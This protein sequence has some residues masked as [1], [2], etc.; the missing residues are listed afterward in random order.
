MQYDII[1]SKKIKAIIF[2]ALKEEFYP[3]ISQIKGI[4]RKKKKTKEC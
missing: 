4:K 3:Q 2:Q 1:I